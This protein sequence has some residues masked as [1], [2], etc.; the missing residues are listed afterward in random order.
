MLPTMMERYVF[1]FILRDRVQR[2]GA[3]RSQILDHFLILRQYECNIPVANGNLYLCLRGEEDPTW[4]K[5]I[6]FDATIDGKLQEA[7]IT[8]TG[9]KGITVKF[10][11][12]DDPSVLSYRE[13]VE[14]LMAFA[15]AKAQKNSKVLDWPAQKFIG[16]FKPFE[17]PGEPSNEEDDMRTRSSDYSLP[18]VTDNSIRGSAKLP[19]LFNLL[20]DEESIKLEPLVCPHLCDE[21]DGERNSN[22]AVYQEMEPS[23]AKALWNA[24]NSKEAFFGSELL[25]IAP[26][27]TKEMPGTEVLRNLIALVCFGP[28]FN[29]TF[30]YPDGAKVGLAFEY[31]KRLVSNPDSAAKLAASALPKYWM[32]CLCQVT[33]ATL[34]EVGDET[35]VTTAALRRVGNSLQVSAYCEE[36]FADLLEF[37]LEESKT[38]QDA[39]HQKTYRSKPIIN[40]MLENCNG[41][42][43]L[44]KMFTRATAHVLIRYGH[45]VLGTMNVPLATEATHCSQHFCHAQAARLASALG[46]IC[47]NL[48]WLHSAESDSNG[49]IL[50]QDCANLMQEAFDAEWLE[51][52]FD[53]SPFLDLPKAKAAAE[54][55]KAKH[56]QR[57]KLHFVTSLKGPRAEELRSCLAQRLDIYDVYEICYSDK[58]L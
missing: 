29:K 12:E 56:W 14:R 35:R 10:R 52:N 30:P 41:T 13:I 24:V 34:C 51:A 36:L 1:V 47:V 32:D 2:R 46:R 23:I 20:E 22:T 57:V 11:G 40:P 43:Q 4:M 42:R 55:L 49:I 27:L 38:D 17:N 5:D 53:A 25:N 9:P 7:R 16:N 50:A 48:A 18:S 26:N 33:K 19:S 45:H 54:K 6:T 39:L 37:Q 15:K 3:Y 58:N 31:L 8:H 44:L 21:T 28:K